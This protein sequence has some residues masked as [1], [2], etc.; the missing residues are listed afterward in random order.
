M[1]ACFSAEA[2]KRSGAEFSHCC[3]QNWGK[4][5]KTMNKKYRGGEEFFFML[6]NSFEREIPWVLLLQGYKYQQY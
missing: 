2:M 1:S 5:V 6:D 3:I 4:T